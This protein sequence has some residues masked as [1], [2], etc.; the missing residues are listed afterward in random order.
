MIVTSVDTVP[1]LYLVDQVYN[2]A[3]LD[4]FLDEDISHVLSKSLPLQEHCT[5]RK[6]YKEFPGNSAW[7]QLQKDVDYG[8][9]NQLGYYKYGLL[10]T[11]YWVDLPGFVMDMHVDNPQVVASM[12]VYLDTA[13]GLGT[14]FVTAHGTVFTVP[15]RKNSGYLMINCGQ[16]HGFPNSAQQTR[17]ST[18]TWLKSKS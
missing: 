1:G 9:V 16:L 11:A 14:Q 3:L 13:D 15:Y 7:H 12:Q 18:Y 10:D 2:P 8:P 6:N 17:R 4:Q 5:L